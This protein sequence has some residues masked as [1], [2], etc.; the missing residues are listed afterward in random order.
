MAPVGDLLS[1]V[2]VSAKPQYGFAIA[3]FPGLAGSTMGAG[4]DVPSMHD[5]LS[6]HAYQDSIVT[7]LKGPRQP[8]FLS[9]C[10]ELLR[11][12]ILSYQNSLKI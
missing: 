5:R 11:C 6:D 12:H 10:L 4:W 2:F 1:S 7:R 9:N 3:V 8:A